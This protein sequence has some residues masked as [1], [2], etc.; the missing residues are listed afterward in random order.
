VGDVTYIGLLSHSERVDWYLLKRFGAALPGILLLS[1]VPLLHGVPGSQQ[2]ASRDLAIGGTVLIVLAGLLWWVLPEFGERDAPAPRTP[3]RKVIAD[4][5]DDL[6]KLDSLWPTVAVFVILPLPAH[7]MHQIEVLMLLQPVS[8]GGFGLGNT[9]AGTIFGVFASVGSLAGL[10]GAWFTLRRVPPERLVYLAI[11]LSTVG[12]LGWWL[13]VASRQ[14]S[15]VWVSVTACLEEFSNS[16]FGVVAIILAMQNFGVLRHYA[17][18]FI[19]LATAAGLSSAIARPIGGW[20]MNH[21][22]GA[23]AIRVL[24]IASLVL[25]AGCAALWSKHRARATV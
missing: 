4:A 12:A 18:A 25:A 13:L 21:T 2:T 10:L 22:S 17:T 20:V 24:A 11:A 8:D 16:F 1:M 14:T 15:L 23:A 6:L 9:D 7:S 19:W 5:T 3:W